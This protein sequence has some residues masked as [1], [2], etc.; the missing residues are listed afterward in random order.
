MA[1]GMEDPLLLPSITLR[2]LNRQP[3]EILERVRHGERVV[4]R[5]YEVAKLSEVEKTSSTIHTT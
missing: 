5:R 4:V 2:E 1:D 3:G